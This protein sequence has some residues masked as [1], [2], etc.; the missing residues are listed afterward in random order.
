MYEYLLLSITVIASL[1][2]VLVT[3]RAYQAGKWLRMSAT[4][5]LS[6]FTIAITSVIA[7]TIMDDSTIKRL[8]R[9][10]TIAVIEFRALGDKHFRASFTEPDQKPIEFD[11]YGD[12]WQ[13]DARVMK[14]SGL[15][16]KLGLKPMY[17][18]ERL[19][20][21]YHDVKQELSGKRS[22]YAL[23][24]KQQLDSMWDYLIKYQE[25]IPW[26]DAQYGSATYM[27]MTNGAVFTIKLSH[28]GILASP[29]NLQASQSVK[30]W[31]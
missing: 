31:M 21:R 29:R 5:V 6:I 12:Q 18:F 24:E 25:L 19:S 26:L 23:A 11:M 4:L 22:V 7:T 28:K 27:P 2:V 8:T 1:L 10:H 20:G 17:Q 9:E 16:A 14:W 13:I 15:A 3:Y 30:Q